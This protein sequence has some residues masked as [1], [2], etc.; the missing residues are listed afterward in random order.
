VSYVSKLSARF[1]VSIRNAKTDDKLNVRHARRCSTRTVNSCT[2]IFVTAPVNRVLFTL[3]CLLVRI[4]SAARASPYHR[5]PLNE[6]HEIPP[7]LGSS[8]RQLLPAGA[9]II[10]LI[11]PPN[12]LHTLRVPRNPIIVPAV[13]RARVSAGRL[14]R[15]IEFRDVKNR[16]GRKSNYPFPG[17]FRGKITSGPGV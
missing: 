12:P 9:F 11:P 2:A 3:H 17:K 13:V 15:V 5:P 6:L 14:T 4:R 10:G 8:R 7:P 16:A 1:C